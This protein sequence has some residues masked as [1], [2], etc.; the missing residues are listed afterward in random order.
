ML[1]VCGTL[2]AQYAFSQN[3][4]S[5]A[6]SNMIASNI[7]KP[8]N[9]DHMVMNHATDVPVAKAVRSTD[10]A[11][12][13][14]V[15]M[16][17]SWKGVVDKTITL[18]TL[19]GLKFDASEIT[20][21]AGSKVKFTFS[22]KDVMPHNFVLTDIG[23]GAEVGQLAMKLGAQGEAMD[24]VPSTPKVLGYTSILQPQKSQTIYFVAPSKPGSYPFICS[25]PGHYM[26]MK[27]VINVT[28]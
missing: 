21:K 14:V 5:L 26:I 10:D 20:V 24:Y 6:N 23:S 15:T 22:N 2:C 13:H 4:I 25:F 16:P 9:H 28:Q 12:K 7:E 8:M 27:G 19:P 17:A 18:G 1:L 11:A 3:S